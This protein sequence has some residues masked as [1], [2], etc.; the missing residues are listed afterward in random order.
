MTVHLD[1]PPDVVER[2]TQEARQK[3]LSLDDYVLQTVLK[4]E[5]PNGSALADD[6]AKREAR[7]RAGRSIRKLRKGNMLG[8]DL[9]V[10]DLIDEGRRF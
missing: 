5:I 7:E 1:W 10:R 2:L 4:K 3:G 9:T 6:S 8:T